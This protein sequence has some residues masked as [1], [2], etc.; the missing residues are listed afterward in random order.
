MTN[1][2]R[3]RSIKRRVLLGIRACLPAVDEL[4]AAK[5]ANGQAQKT[6]N[7][8]SLRIPWKD[9]ARPRSPESR[10]PGTASFKLHYCPKLLKV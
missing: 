5:K 8:R 1:Q 4:D 10:I 9:Y 6:R 2:C 3:T 7:L